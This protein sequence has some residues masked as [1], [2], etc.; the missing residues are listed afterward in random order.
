MV[1]HAV[2]SRALPVTADARFSLAIVACITV[3]MVLIL[4]G[5]GLA[6]SGFASAGPAVRAQYPDAAQ[7]APGG[8]EGRPPR[9]ADL[10][11]AVRDH[12]IP[13]TEQ[14]QVR[15]RFAGALG[16]SAGGLRE[17]GSIPLLLGGIAVFAVGGFLRSRRDATPL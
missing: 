7:L 17:Y 12:P 15:E 16:E 2:R 1:T 6:I 10:S 14:A 3:G 8:T 5:T 11:R 13:P 4:S 9:L